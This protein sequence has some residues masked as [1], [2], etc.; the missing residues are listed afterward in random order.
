MKSK[1]I[2]SGVL[3]AL[4]VIVPIEVKAE[5][6]KYTDYTFVDMDNLVV[7]VPDTICLSYDSLDK[8]FKGRNQIIVTGGEGYSVE[9]A[10]D[11]TQIAYAHEEDSSL[12]ANGLVNFGTDGVETWS[13]DEVSSSTG[14]DISVVVS[15][16]PKEA[17]GTYRTNINYSINVSEAQKQANDRYFSKTVDKSTGTCTIT[18]FTDEGLAWL[19]S[20]LEATET[21]GAKEVNE[22]IIPEK[23]VVQGKEYTVTAIGNHAFD[24]E[25]GNFLKEYDDKANTGTQT[26]YSEYQ[27]RDKYNI[28][29]VTIPNTV[30][31]IGDFAFYRSKKLVEVD[32]PDNIKSIGDSA[33]RESPMLERVDMPNTV[34]SIG[35]YA[36]YWCR[37]L[38]VTELPANIKSIGSNA[39]NQCY[40]LKVTELP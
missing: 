36:F 31:S 29:K 17:I 4:M 2:M 39:F 32:L 8:S 9:V 21:T 1:R 5:E 19:E 7:S 25:G 37:N 20:S 35:D 16:F 12:T 27:Y 11:S 30:E 10:V 14:K 24:L 23:L 34:E 26:N 3:A 28:S 6:I 13:E 40:K 15:E 38:N 33:F 22:L 18:G